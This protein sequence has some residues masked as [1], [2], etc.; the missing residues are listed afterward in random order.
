MRSTQAAFDGR[1][2]VA[3]E[4]VGAP[5]RAADALHSSQSTSASRRT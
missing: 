4:I 5:Q 1:G 2:D 3:I